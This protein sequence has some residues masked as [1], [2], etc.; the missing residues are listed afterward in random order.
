MAAKN[1]LLST[2]LRVLTPEEI[3]EL[4]TTSIGDNRVLLTD[5]INQR[6]SGVDHDFSDSEKMAKILPFKKNSEE[7]DVEKVEVTKAGP[8]CL[9]YLERFFERQKISDTALD[10]SGQLVE[11]SSFIFK[12]K[13]R[14]AYSQAKLKQVEVL[15]LYKKNAA[16][17]VEQVRALKD[18]LSKSAQSG[19]L[20]NKKQY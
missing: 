17:D 11:T 6:L 19:V 10:D 16:V 12:E 14:F 2:I 13:E 9:E 4:T 1:F 7:V 20:I 3:N 5:I 18:D 15:S 8:T